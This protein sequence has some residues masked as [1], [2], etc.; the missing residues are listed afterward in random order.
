MSG[1]GTV[2]SGGALHRDACYSI[3]PFSLEVVPELNWRS[4]TRRYYINLITYITGEQ[5]YNVHQTLVSFLKGKLND[6]HAN[7]KDHHSKLK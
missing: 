6:T 1:G 7:E 5:S 3:R 2:V 4:P